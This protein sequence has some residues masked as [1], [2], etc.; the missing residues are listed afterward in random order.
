MT[1]APCAGW[2]EPTAARAS[3]PRAVVRTFSQAQLENGAS[4]LYLGVHYG[5]D[6]LQG[7][8]LGLAV[9]DTI[10]RG[11]S[12]PA[13]AGVRVRESPASFLGLLPTLLLRPDLYGFYGRDTRAPN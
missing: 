4:R 5:Y 12:D 2:W 9:A 6:N 7:Q 13:A 11:A 3:P 8:L 10:I 1:L